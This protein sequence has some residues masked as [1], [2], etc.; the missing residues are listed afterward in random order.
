MKQI[1]LLLSIVILSAVLC[2]CYFRPNTINGDGNIITKEIQIKDY[3][4][5]EI[6]LNNVELI[7]QQSEDTPILKIETDQNI[8]DIIDIEQEGK[9]L[10]L[11]HQREFTQTTPT[12]LI[13]TTNSTKLKELALAGSGIYNLGE[14]IFG[15][16]L[17]IK[18]AGNCRVQ[19]D[20]IIV[21]DLDCKI[22]GKGELYLNGNVKETNIESAGNSQ[23]EAF[24]LHTDILEC[25]IAGRSHIEI[26]VNQQITAQIAG[27]ADILYK[28]DPKI[29]QQSIGKGSIKQVK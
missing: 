16:E 23:I 15:E 12:Y 9:E 26:T 19:A 20:S 10:T 6:E 1:S 27:K 18:L 13:I 21:N 2:S 17:E 25:E 3:E 14:G 7:Y 4:Q 5:L 29:T 28:G 11:K 24:G 22:A 8:M